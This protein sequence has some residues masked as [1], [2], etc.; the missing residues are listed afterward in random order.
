[1]YVYIKY[2]IIIKEYINEQYQITLPAGDHTSKG[3][4]PVGHLPQYYQS[5]YA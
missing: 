2:M 3:D 5:K 4:R 1:M